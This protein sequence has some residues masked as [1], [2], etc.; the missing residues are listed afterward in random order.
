MHFGAFWSKMGLGMDSKCMGQSGWTNLRTKEAKNMKNYGP[1]DEENSP[2]ICHP[3]LHSLPCKPHRIPFGF[4][5]HILD[6]IYIHYMHQLMLHHSHLESN[7]MCNTCCCTFDPFV[8]TFHLPFH[9]YAMY[10]IIHAP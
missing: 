5:C 1:K 7:A 3:N 9:L 4:P 10:T 2:K 8:D 6:N